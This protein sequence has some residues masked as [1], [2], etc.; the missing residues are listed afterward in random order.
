LRPNGSLGN[1]FP[2]RGRF[3]KSS[4]ARIVLRMVRG[5]LS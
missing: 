3:R 1:K 5:D 2:A 4:C